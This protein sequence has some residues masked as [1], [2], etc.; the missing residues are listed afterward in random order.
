M[1]PPKCRTCDRRGYVYDG[2]SRVVCPDC[3]GTGC[4]EAKQL[5]KP[6]E[7]IAREGERGA[8]KRIARQDARAHYF[9]E[10]NVAEYHDA[11]KVA[12]CQFCS[13]RMMEKISA[14][15]AAHK[16]RRWKG[17]D[18]FENMCAVEHVCHEWQGQNPEAEKFLLSSPVNIVTGGVVAWPEHL[19]ADLL[20]YK[21]RFKR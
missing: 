17:D 3:K 18:S 6:T 2:P 5:A 9:E 14:V 13:A 1:K 10:H 12:P 21:E 4:R 7:G 15:D 11:L 19:K 8:A 20:A 16:E